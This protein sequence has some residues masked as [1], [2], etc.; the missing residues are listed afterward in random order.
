MSTPL[1][2][3]PTFD[4][5]ANVTPF[6]YRDGATYLSVLETVR[7]NVN[8]AIE[9]INTNVDGI[10]TLGEISAAA[11]ELVNEAAADAAQAALA[12][13]DAANLVNAPAKEVIDILMGGDSAGLVARVDAAEVDIDDLQTSDVAQ[14]LRL[15]RGELPLNALD[16]GAD[17]AAPDNTAAFNA[18]MTAARLTKRPAYIPDGRW[19][20]YGEVD[21]SGCDIFGD[22][23]GYQNEYGTTIIGD[24]TGITFNQ[25]QTNKEFVTTHIHGLRFESVGTAI[26]LSYALNC[27]IADVYVMDSTD[28]SLILGDANLAG[29]MW[30]M[31]ERCRF[32]AIN[33]KSGL[34]MSGAAWNNANTFDTIF[35][36]SDIGP[37][38]LFGNVGGLGAISNVFD[39]CEIMSGG[40]GVHF[41]ETTQNTTINNGYF[42]CDSAAIL[43]DGPTQS[44]NMNNCVYGTLK[45]NSVPA[46]PAFIY[47]L[48]AT[49]SVYVSGGW[50]TL[51]NSP[52]TANLRFIDSANV[53][54]LILRMV[55]DPRQSAVLADGW[56]LF[57]ETKMNA[58]QERKHGPVYF[59]KYSQ[60]EIQIR[61]PDG[62]K[63]VRIYRNGIQGG[64]DF[65]VGI[66]SD[67]VTAMMIT[68]DGRV[69]LRE[70]FTS[71]KSEVANALGSV[72]RR[73]RIKD[74][75]GTVLGYIPIYDTIT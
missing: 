48:S 7:Q 32:A 36:K 49:A 26:R 15:D 14:S 67:G 20:V 30:N 37:A 12:A 51:P 44:L 40:V 23:S 25:L 8:T 11:V 57:D 52:N 38:I 2:I 46:Y 70:D 31:F 75:L 10:N 19:N 35:F 64:A 69:T 22:V 43:I 68:P 47:H 61:Y 16:Y 4:P 24:G 29:P 3:I 65:G 1:P 34:F 13:V 27:R 72:V 53:A 56:K 59:E 58:Y 66:Q 50:V 45:N 41:T 71:Q 6:T 62:S 55:T 73:L 63:P 18:L 33:G 9:G 21:I 17:T 74:E 5:I 42:E 28:H 39:N 54:G 60:P